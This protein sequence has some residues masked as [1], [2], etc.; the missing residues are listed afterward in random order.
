MKGGKREGAGRPRK[1]TDALE[2][3]ITIRL[4]L[5]EAEHLRADAALKGISVAEAARDAIGW[6][7]GTDR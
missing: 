3:K 5:D 2:A 1:G 6:Y 7:L 4:T